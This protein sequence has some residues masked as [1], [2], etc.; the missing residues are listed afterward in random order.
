MCTI[1]VKRLEDW[2]CPV[3]VWLGKLTTLD[4]TQIGQHNQT[5]KFYFISFRTIEPI[6]ILW[7]SNTTQAGAV[8]VCGLADIT[9]V[10]EEA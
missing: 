5:N 9:A 10:Y 1:L 2:A 4:M 6:L 8:D 3:K 7:K